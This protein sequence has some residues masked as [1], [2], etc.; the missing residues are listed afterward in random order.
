MVSEVGYIKL[1]LVWSQGQA[2]VSQGGV[3]YPARGYSTCSM[4]KLFNYRYSLR[5]HFAEEKPK[6]VIQLAEVESLLS[7]HCSSLASLS[8]SSLHLEV[9]EDTVPNESILRE[10]F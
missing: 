9:D 1:A 4:V 8:Q 6:K 5:F 2:G 7:K 10:E 3:R